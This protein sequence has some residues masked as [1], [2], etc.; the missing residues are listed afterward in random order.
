VAE[1]VDATKV[2]Q[3]GPNLQGANK[4]STPVLTKKTLA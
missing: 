2:K 3:D 4:L 1:L